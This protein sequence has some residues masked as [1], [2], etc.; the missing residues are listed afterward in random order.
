MLW[1]NGDV[2]QAAGDHASSRCLRRV[3]GHGTEKIE[4]EDVWGKVTSSRGKSQRNPPAGGAEGEGGQVDRPGGWAGSDC[5]GH[6]RAVGSPLSGKA[7]EEERKEERSDV[8]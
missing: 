7:Q 1:D 8:A 5:T 3:Q 4:G 2:Q 6:G